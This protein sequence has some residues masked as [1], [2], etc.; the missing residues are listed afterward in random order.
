MHRLA[1]RRR[2]PVQG[3][4]AEHTPQGALA[5]PVAARLDG[6]LA[7]DVVLVVVDVQ[8]QGAADVVL[9][10]L[11]QAA[12]AVQHALG[13][14]QDVVAVGEQA[15]GVGGRVGGHVEHVPD[16]GDDRDGRPLQ[17]QAE[18]GGARGDGDVQGAGSLALWGN[19]LVYIMTGRGEGGCFSTFALQRPSMTELPAQLRTSWAKS[20]GSESS[21]GFE[22]SAREHGWACCQRGIRTIIRPLMPTTKSNHGS[23]ASC[24]LVLRSTWNPNAPWFSL[25]AGAGSPSRRDMKRLRALNMVSPLCGWCGTCVAVLVGCLWWCRVGLG[26]AVWVVVWTRELQ[27]GLAVPQRRRIGARLCMGCGS[28]SGLGV[29]EPL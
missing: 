2:Q 7:G 16:V 20:P 25:A 18:R 4:V 28:N 23:M 24:G 19:G 29:I 13:G 27:L 8:A 10:Q 6:D 5:A 26:G 17:G 14:A 1:Q 21:W 22:V 11:A 3:A 15:G 12:L 9:D